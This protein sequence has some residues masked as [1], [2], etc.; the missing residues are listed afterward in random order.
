MKVYNLHDE[1]AKILNKHGFDA[2]FTRKGK[3]IVT[4]TDKKK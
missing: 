2:K 4:K 1:I 3:V